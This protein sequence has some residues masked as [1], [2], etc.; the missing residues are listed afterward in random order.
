MA[1]FTSLRLTNLSGSDPANITLTCQQG[2]GLPQVIP[3][4]LGP[5]D[6]ADFETTLGCTL[7]PCN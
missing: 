6:T 2:S 5:G 3:I 1:L 4:A 7:D